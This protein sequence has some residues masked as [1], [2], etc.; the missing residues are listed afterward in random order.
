ML[1]WGFLGLNLFFSFA[2]LPPGADVFVMADKL[3]HLLAYAATTGAFLLAAVWRPGR[4]PG[5]YP[6]AASAI[7]A[8]AVALSVASEVLQGAVFDRDADVLDTVADLLG[9]A[10]AYVGWRVLRGPGS[11]AT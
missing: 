1:A 10:A 4:G 3:L 9:V 7:V 8:V 5:R 2:P 6:R 11:T